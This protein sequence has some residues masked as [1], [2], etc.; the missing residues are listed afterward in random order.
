MRKSAIFVILFLLLVTSLTAE[1]R[2]ITYQGKVTDADGVGLSGIYNVVFKVYDDLSAGVLLHEVTVTDVP[3]TKGLFSCY[4]DLELT[5]DEFES[6]LYLEVEFGGDRLLP[7]MQVTSEIMS[8]YSTFSQNSAAADSSGVSG[9]AYTSVYADTSEYTEF[10]VLATDADSANVAGLAHAA[11]NADSAY[12][13]GIAHHSYHTDQA[14]TS[15]FTELAYFADSARVSVAAYHADS[16]AAINWSDIVEI[17]ADIADGDDGTFYRIR[18][19]DGAPFTDSVKVREGDNIS[20]VQYGNNLEIHADIPDFLLDGDDEGISR[21]KIDGGTYITDSLILAEGEYIA[22]EQAGRTVT[23]NTDL[24]EDLADGDDEGFLKMKAAGNGWLTDS[25][26]I[27]GS[28]EITVTQHLDTIKIDFTADANYI[29]TQDTLIQD[30]AFY[31]DGP[32][33]V[34]GG[35]WDEARTMNFGGMDGNTKNYPMAGDAAYFRSVA[36]FTGAE[37][38]LEAGVLSGMQLRVNSMPTLNFI[39]SNVNIWVLQTSATTVPTLWST[40]GAKNVLNASTFTIPFEASGWYE[41]AFADTVHYD[42]TSNIMIFIEGRTA[43]GF[44]PVTAPTYFYSEQRSDSY[45]AW[46]NSTGAYSDAL[47]RTTMRSDFGLVFESAQWTVDG[48]IIEEDMIT[49][50]GNLAASGDVEAETF[51]LSGSSI[52]S[53]DEIGPFLNPDYDTIAGTHHDTIVV[54]NDMKVVGELIADSIQAAGDL[55]TIDDDMSVDGTVTVGEFFTLDR[56][57]LLL[58]MDATLTRTRS[59]HQVS[60]TGYEM[61]LNGTTA[62][63][64]GAK[65]GQVLILEGTDDEY[66]VGIPAGSNTMMPYR[67]VLGEGETIMLIWNGSVWVELARTQQTIPE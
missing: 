54:N 67:C 47:T 44:L 13:A 65:I 17:P 39:H 7:R 41:F 20:F 14:D 29:H 26:V 31:I 9:A 56:T 15:A 50:D 34:G 23:I 51:T 32:G 8:F 5:L 55:L 33:R 19:Q 52:Y 6:D 59:Y 35:S 61:V 60:G 12:K 37:L 40:T 18:F 64:D 28:N 3:V 62:I 16:A 46:N 45:M 1:T 43:P 42:G 36:M 22:L 21:I 10:A 58:D 11:E 25:S 30:A 48:V 2:R 49:L 27:T 66:A 53:W 57:V 4:F 24:P 38:N 63:A